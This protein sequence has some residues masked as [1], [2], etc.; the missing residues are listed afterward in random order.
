MRVV[1]LKVQGPLEKEHWVRMKNFERF[2]SKD[3]PTDVT[4][5][6]E[7]AREVLKRFADKAYRRPVDEKTL[8]RLVKIAE[9]TYSLPKKSF[10]DGIAAAMTPVLASPRFLFRIEESEVGPNSKDHPLVDEYSLAARLSYFLWSTMP[11]EELTRLAA[12]HELRKNLAKQVDRM[13]H[14]DRSDAFMASFVG[15]WLQVRDVE[16]I[17]INSRA[18]IARDGQGP[19]REM[20]AKFKRFR[21]LR[22]IEENKLTPE[23]AAEVKELRTVLFRGGRRNQGPELD[24]NLR[25]AL[26]DEVEKVFAYIARGDR[27]VIELIES[28]Y[29]FLNEKL[30]THYGIKDVSGTEMRL[31]KLPADSPRGGILTHGA[32]L[33]V[34]SNPDRTSPVKRG[35]FILDNILG[36]PPPPPPPDIPALEEAEKEITGKR[37]TTREALELHRSKPLCH[38]CHNRMDPLGF[39][40]ENFNAMGM[41][42]EMER[43]QKVDAAGSLVT[44]EQ[45]G[46]IRE[47]KQVLAS[48]YRTQ[49][50]RCLTEKML[51]Y[52]LGRGLD[53]YDVDAVDRIV[54][55]LM[56][57]NGKF[58]ALLSGIIESAPFQK[59]RNPNFQENLPPAKPA[60]TRASLDQ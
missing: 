27:S 44:G 51:T 38:S 32:T 47:V 35:L 20:E 7:Y 52:A 53:Y 45:F 58:S 25:R 34:T 49:F 36:I 48:K 33:I 4:Q 29:T 11:D 39:A 31:V 8:G 43:G 40:L 60:E 1:H 18:V 12:K 22:D 19:D 55:N 46:N 10:E 50:Y 28:D 15:Q 16:G 54:E 9:E 59:R 23:Q 2:F 26:R 56:K 37:P 41:W 57:E 21:E 42:R 6:R 3:P 5:R 14:D 17:D 30:A 24:G 13:L